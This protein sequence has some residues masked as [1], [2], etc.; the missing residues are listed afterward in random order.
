MLLAGETPFE[1]AGRGLRSVD[2]AIER[3]CLGFSLGRAPKETVRMHGVVLFV[4][5]MRL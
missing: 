5:N 4:C 3:A 2:L 1:H